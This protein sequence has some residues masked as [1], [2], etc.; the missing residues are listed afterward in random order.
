MKKQLILGTLSLCMVMGA[1]VSAPVTAFAKPV[2]I[3]DDAGNVYTYDDGMPTEEELAAERA[4]AEEANRAAAEEEQRR[5]AEDI[6]RGQAEAEAQMRDYFQQQT[7]NTYEWMVANGQD[8]TEIEANMQREGIAYTPNP[9]SKGT[10]SSSNASS[11][12]VTNNIEAQ[13]QIVS[14]TKDNVSKNKSSSKAAESKVKEEKSETEAKLDV[15]DEKKTEDTEQLTAAKTAKKLNAANK[16]DAEKE[17]NAEGGTKVTFLKS[18]GNFF[19]GIF[20]GASGLWEAF[21]ARFK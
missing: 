11:N 3:T 15:A 17:I 13:K 4:A 6:A 18:V 9:N 7:L 19:T 12:G 21:V 20:K 1:I 2:T 8:T 14:E 10:Q 5:I 16:D